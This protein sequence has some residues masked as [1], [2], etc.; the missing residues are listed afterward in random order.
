MKTKAL[1]AQIMKSTMMTVPHGN[2]ALHAV[3]S[4]QDHM[5]HVHGTSCV[6]TDLS[7]VY[8]K[9]CVLQIV[10]YQVTVPSPLL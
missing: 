8:Y 7:H 6:S 10:Q 9:E 4:M 2:S 3:C 1:L 5:N